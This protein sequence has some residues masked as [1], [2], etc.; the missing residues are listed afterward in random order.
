[1]DNTEDKIYGLAS[2][3]LHDIKAQ[4]RRWTIAFFV[5]LGL[6]FAT[7][8]GIGVYFYSY[9][10]V[11]YAQ[12]GSGYNNINTGEQGDVTNGATLDSIEAARK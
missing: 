12:D 9:D 7:L 11:T 10:T 3:M 2:E 4:S 1:M 6:W 5:V 8:C